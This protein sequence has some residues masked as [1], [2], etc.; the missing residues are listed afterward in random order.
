MTGREALR[1]LR[2]GRADGPPRVRGP[3]RDRLSPEPQPDPGTTGV[4]DGRPLGWRLVAG[5][6]IFVFGLIGVWILSGDYTPP[7]PARCELLRTQS[8]YTPDVALEMER[9]GCVDPP[10]RLRDLDPTARS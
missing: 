7:D 8:L 9:L 6:L 1:D 5:I 2:Q 3:V 10:H 4:S